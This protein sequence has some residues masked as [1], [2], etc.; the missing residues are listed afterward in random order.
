MAAVGGMRFVKKI[1]ILT[2]IDIENNPRPLR[3]I[4]LLKDRYE[5][6]AAG[7]KAS[8]Y[9]DKYFQLKKMRIIKRMLRLLLLV[10]KRYE[11]Y[12]WDDNKRELL[13]TLSGHTY[14]LIIAHDEDT[15]PIAFK[16]SQNAK[17]LLDAH[18]YFAGEECNVLWRLFKKEYANYLCQRYLP[19][20]SGMFTVCDGIAKEYYDKYAV[21]SEVIMNVPKYKNILPAMISNNKV[22]LIYHGLIGPIRKSEVMIE[23]MDYLDD[24][25]TLDFMVLYSNINK[26]YFTRLKRMARR[27]RNIRFIAPVRFDD[28]IIKTNDYDIGVFLLPPTN[29]SDELALPNKLFEFIQ[30]RLAIAI[31]PSPEM[32]KIVK[33]YDLGIVSDDFTPRSM[34]AAIMSTSPEK[35]MYYKW[36][37]NKCAKT[38]SYCFEGK[39]IIRSIEQLIN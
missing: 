27:N 29:R 22:R 3:Q 17:V 2:L 19:L 20:V 38:L 36:Q 16:I 39:K 26:P 30:A 4:K 15:L 33:Q 21:K 12:Y 18:E 34:A 24:K 14:D 32:V 11:K 37:A 23:M 13:R 35:I 28:I 5:I 31:G 6:H 8:G 9:E 10:F 7:T 25:Y 1:L